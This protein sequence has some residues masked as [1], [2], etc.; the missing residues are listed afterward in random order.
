MLT[1]A[2]IL[3]K[4]EIPFSL[5]IVGNGPLRGD[6]FL[7]R[8]R[9]NLNEE[10]F[11]F[12]FHE[13][14]VSPSVIPGIR[15]FLFTGIVDS[16]GDRDGIPNVVPEALAAGMLVIASDRAGAPEA[17]IDGKSGFSL[18][19]EDYMAWVSILMDFWKF[20]EKYLNIRKN[21]Q[22]VARENFDSEINGCKLLHA[23]MN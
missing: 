10:S 1:I 12:W 2:N 4:S 3:K 21:G 9:L 11:V 5:E 18:N 16:K 22:L 20:P 17:F 13:P 23:Y 6:L 14:K 19:P 8:R 7:E 15:C